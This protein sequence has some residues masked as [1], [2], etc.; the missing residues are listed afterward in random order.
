MKKIIAGVLLLGAVAFVFQRCTKAELAGTGSTSTT[1]VSSTLAAIASTSGQLASGTNFTISGTSSDSSGT[2]PGS[3]QGLGGHHPGLPP[4]LDGTTLLA[5]T[6][7]LLAI[8]DAES[9]GDLRGIQMHG[10]SGATITN[11]DSAGNILKHPMPMNGGEGCSFSGG[12]FPQTDSALASISKTVIDFG[13]GVTE[14]HDTVTITRIG[15]IIIT[16]TKSG[17]T[18]T[19][20]IVFSGYSVNGNSIEGTKTRVSSEV[21][22]GTTETGSSTT[23]VTNGKITFNDGSVAAW[24]GTNERSSTITLSASGQPLTGEVT[25]EGSTAF[26][27]SD[28]TVIFSDKITKTITENV[29]CRYKHHGPVSGT[30]ETIYR[31]NT[32]T[33][34][35]GDG[36]CNNNSV[37]ITVNGVTT[38]KTVGA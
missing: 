23:N 11:Y 36:S 35:F 6:N 2:T 20:T 27:L 18:R 28:G 19:E 4:P 37:T 15:K 32:I 31:T 25:T 29:A 12:Q 17:T 38:T 7:E 9:A 8:I 1:T 26:T 14:K 10:H 22:S 30:V 16:R 13:T 33:I 3:G 34:D 5:P 21:K 24:T